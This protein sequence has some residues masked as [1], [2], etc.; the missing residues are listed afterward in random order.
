M[1][2]I[3]PGMGVMS[4]VGIVGKVKA[5][6]DHFATVVSLLHPA[7]QVSAKLSHS[8]VL[9]TI[10][11]TGRDPFRAQLLYVPRHVQIELGDAVVT[12]GYNATFLA[13]TMIGHVERLGL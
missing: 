7:M 8:G 12:S 13:G 10:Q 5:V 11:W 6:S 3:T 9:G 1:H 2:G 4:A